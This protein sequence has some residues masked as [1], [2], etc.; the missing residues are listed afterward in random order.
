MNNMEIKIAHLYPEKLNL[1][2]DRGNITSMVYRLKSRGI[3]CEVKEYDI[4]ENIDFENI[5]IIYLGGGTDKDQAQVREIL[6]KRQID[7]KAYVE[8]GGTV[9][10]VCGSYEMLG[11][12]CQQNG[13]KELCLDILDMYTIYAD[14]RQI[15]N[16][17]LKNDELDYEIAGFENHGGVVC[18]NVDTPLGKVIK[19]FG[20]DGKSGVEGAIY[21][22][23]VATYLHGPLLPK[24]PKLCDFIL[25]K[26]IEQKYGKYE[27]APLDDTLENAA[28]DY[29]VKTFS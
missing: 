20:N 26:A 1:Y 4:D 27:L 13:K 6:L 2:G 16:I 28:H 24:N 29:A 14:N 15:G 23:V 8:N 5:D 19:G 10:A 11:K 3:E 12:Y 25:L 17:V 18:S 9:L 7:F 22:N 21:K